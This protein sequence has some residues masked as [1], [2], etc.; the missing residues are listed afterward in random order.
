MIEI[1]K[2]RMV[3]AAIFG[4]PPFLRSQRRRKAK[5]AKR[6]DAEDTEKHSPS[7]RK[8]ECNCPVENW[9]CQKPAFGWGWALAG[10]EASA[11]SL[12]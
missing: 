11:L 10:P 12:A 6:G 7:S 8:G 5:K 2:L 1:R 3:L 9:G 4:W